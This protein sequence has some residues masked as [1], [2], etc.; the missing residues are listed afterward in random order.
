MPAM[1]NKPNDNTTIETSTSIREKPEGLWGRW[2]ACTTRT[3]RIGFEVFMCGCPMTPMIVS[4]R[5]NQA[6]PVARWS[7]QYDRLAALQDLVR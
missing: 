1:P 7:S 3:A 4:G 6:I 5:P 2:P